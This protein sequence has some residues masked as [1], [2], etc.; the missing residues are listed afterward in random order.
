MDEEKPSLEDLMHFGKKGMRWGVRNAS[1]NLARARTAKQ[2]KLHEDARDSKG[3][4]GA[5]AML[6]K[7]TWGGGGRFEGYHNTKIS[8]LKKSQ[9]RIDRG[10]LVARTIIFGPRYSKK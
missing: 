3:L 7:Y 10:E 4:T 2:I 6:D 8:E 1:Q 9:D 5:I